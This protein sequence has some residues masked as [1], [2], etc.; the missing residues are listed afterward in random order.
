MLSMMPGA[1]ANAVTRR[2]Y[3]YLIRE[4]RAVPNALSGGAVDPLRH[5]AAA[6]EQARD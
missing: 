1:P 6:G 3:Q 5:V 2:R 4:G